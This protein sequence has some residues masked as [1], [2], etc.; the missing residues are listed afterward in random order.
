MNQDEQPTDALT[1]LFPQE[2]AVRLN[3][4]PIRGRQLFQWLHKR[5]VFDVDCMTDMPKTERAR[6]GQAGMLTALTP[7]QKQESP[8]TGATKMLFEL[9]D[10]ETVESVL[11]IQDAHHTLCLSSQ[12]GCPLGCTFCA[13]GQAGFRRNLSPAEI[14]EQALCLMGEIPRENESTPN[15]VLMGMGEP[16]L[17]YDAVMKSIRLLMHRE[18]MHVGA[19]KITVST[20]GEVEGIRRFALEPWQV[21]LSV[22]LHAADDDLRSQLVPLNRHYPLKE[23]HAAL[24]HYQKLRNRQV[25]IEWVLMEGVND[26]PEQAKA[27]S[28]FLRGLDAV[29]NLIPW[30]TVPGLPYLPSS[31]EQREQFMRLLAKAGIKATLRKERG[32]DIDAACGQLRNIRHGA[33]RS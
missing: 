16:F 19:R 31:L 6:L 25:T 11:L 10:G 23:L 18:G 24:T 3:L 12:A 28:S 22:S 9:A 15:I 7:R 32:N 4:P 8:K 2:L 20:A 27:L 33:P 26:N 14:T 21:R 1:G 13:T 30:N 29:V 17:N 5:R